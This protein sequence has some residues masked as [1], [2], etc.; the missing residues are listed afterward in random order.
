MEA[1]AQGPV[2]AFTSPA[3][4]FEPSA[5]RALEHTILPKYLPKQRWFGAK[6]RSIESVS[7]VDWIWLR[8]NFRLPPSF[9]WR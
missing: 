3:A 4:M 7:I 2:I 6:A 9:W 1:V 5:R 8:R